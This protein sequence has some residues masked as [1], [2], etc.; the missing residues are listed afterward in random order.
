MTQFI[1]R[2]N[3]I[4]TIFYQYF[5]TCYRAYFQ[6]IYKTAMML[7]TPH[8]I[9]ICLQETNIKAQFKAYKVAMV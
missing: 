5:K 2:P 3:I 9:L 4:C 7:K 6:H 8:I 1:L